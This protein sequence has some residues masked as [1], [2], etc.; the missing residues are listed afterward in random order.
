MTLNIQRRFD[1]KKGICLPKTPLKVISYGREQATI[2][3]HEIIE[4][5]END[6]RYVKKWFVLS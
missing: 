6:I 2:G 3:N 1:G 4:V 5:I